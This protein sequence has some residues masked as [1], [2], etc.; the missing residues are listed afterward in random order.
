[1]RTAAATNGPK[2]GTIL[3]GANTAGGVANC[4]PHNGHE[5]PI[6]KIRKLISGNSRAVRRSLSI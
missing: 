3:I 5:I 2:Y 1:M 4:R 6:L